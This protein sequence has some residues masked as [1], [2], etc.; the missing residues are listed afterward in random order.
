MRQC[1]KFPTHADVGG[2]TETHSTGAIMDGQIDIDL[3]V[4]TAESEH[5]YHARCGEYL[6][7]HL[8]ADFRK[9]PLLYFKRLSGLIED[10]D[11]TAY[12]VG[13]ATHCRILE[14]RSEYEKRFAFGGPVNPKTGKPFGSQTK[15]FSDWAE[16][17]GKPVL[18]DEHVPLIENLAQGVAMNSNAVDL[19]LDGQAEGV[20]RVEYCGA[21]CQVRIDWL[22]PYRGIVDLKTCDDLTWLEAD[23]KRYGY[24]H[25]MAF[26]RAVLARVL[27]Q[28]LVPVHIIAAEKKQPFRCGV[29]LIDDGVLAHAQRENE[30][31][32]RR[33]LEC[34]KRNAWPTGYEEVRVLDCI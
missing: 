5:E 12:L 30:A 4:L 11:S 34:Q 10:K 13:R 22:H 18:K 7:S 16:A 19:L 15:A 25:Q 27:G 21:P 8:L 1:D 14:G 29:W 23:A 20:V 9:C 26:Y 24:V 2:R 6:S 31:A 33:L 3:T 28:S 32:I 17:Q